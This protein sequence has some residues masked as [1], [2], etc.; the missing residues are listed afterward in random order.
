MAV[1]TMALWP[2][3]N[4]L[5][6][7]TRRLED[8]AAA[9]RAEVRRVAQVLDRPVATYNVDGEEFVITVGDVAAAKANLLRPH[10]EEAI[11][12]I[13]LADKIGRRRRKLPPQEQEH[14]FWK[15]VEAIRDQAIADG[16]AIDDPMEAVVGD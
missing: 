16:T 14:L 13:A 5:Q 8:E 11:Y 6:E 3:L 2:L 1:E 10:S 7:R 15:N 12:T 9:L 4:S